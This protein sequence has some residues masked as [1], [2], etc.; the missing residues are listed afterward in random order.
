MSGPDVCMFMFMFD[1]YE[2][3][4]SFEF[5]FVN[6]STTT[7]ISHSLRPWNDR[8]SRRTFADTFV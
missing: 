7:G 8:L 1:S 3:C 5:N 2:Y 6:I 4:D